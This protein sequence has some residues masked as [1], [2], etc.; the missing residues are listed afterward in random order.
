LGRRN[1]E[2]IHATTP[3][4]RRRGRARGG[5]SGIGAGSALGEPLAEDRRQARL[6]ALGLLGLLAILAGVFLIA[7]GAAGAPSQFVPGRSGGWPSWMAGPLQGIGLGISS[8]SFQTL[9]LIV[10]A[11]YLLVL[12]AARALSF[13]VLVAAIVAA[14]VILLLGPPLISQDVFGYIAFAR[15]GVLH[16]LDPYTHVAFDAPTDP[17]YPFIGWPFQHSPYGPLFTLSSYA[18]A[19]LGI[20][21]ALWALKAAAVMGSLLA[22]ALTARA[23]GALGRSRSFAAAFVG[24]NP[25]MLELAV[26][27]AHNDTLVLAFLGGALALTAGGAVAAEAG[28]T[29]D[30]RGSLPENGDARAHGRPV[31]RAA[32]RYR[33]GALTLAAGVGIKVTAGIVLPFLVLAPPSRRE[34]F[35]VAAA[36]ALGLV[37]VA[38]VG[39]I[40]FGSHALGFLDAV[41]EQQQLI[42]THSIPAETA[43]LL[44]LHGTPGWWRHCFLAAFAIVL[45]YA[46]W[47]TARGADWRI[48]AGW[49]TLALLL[50]TAWLLPWYAVWPL[51]LAAVCGDRRLRAATLLVCAYAILIHLPLA[52]PLLSAPAVH[53]APRHGH[54]GALGR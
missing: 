40:G 54:V 48:A 8:A 44:G 52:D 5:A 6:R 31:A 7:A 19:P 11:G 42:A 24:L 3:T 16:G 47:R 45:C 21:S 25:I 37:L 32:P 39:L 1:N 30:G 38:G 35:R 28:K 18:V 2:R 10:C 50:S 53:T 22:V 29:I 17:I 36:A 9:T 27:G 15:M 33:A 4:S 46:L 20:A 14:H 13:S 51:P 41:G 26:G 34:R 49:S 12:A 23:A 43:R